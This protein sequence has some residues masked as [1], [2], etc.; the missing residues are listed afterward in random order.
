MP[1]PLNL[2]CFRHV[3]G[4][5]LN[6]ALLERLNAS[7]SLY[8]THT[9]LADRFTLRLCVGQTHTEERHVAQGLGNDS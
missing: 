2:V 6:R 8:L 1:T 5:E 7:G 4:D 9:T 3:G